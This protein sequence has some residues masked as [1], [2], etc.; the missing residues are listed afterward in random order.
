MMCLQF[1]P[2]H[3]AQTMGNMLLEHDRHDLV[4]GYRLCSMCIYGCIYCQFT[5]FQSTPW[6][7]RQNNQFEITL[8]GFSHSTDKILLSLLALSNNSTVGYDKLLLLL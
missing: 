4:N 1:L 8:M 3:V 7:L 6:F 2:G 5:C